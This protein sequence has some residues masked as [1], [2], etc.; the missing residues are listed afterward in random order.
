MGSRHRVIG[1]KYVFCDTSERLCGIVVV[2]AGST[3]CCYRCLQLFLVIFSGGSIGKPDIGTEGEPMF[4]ENQCNQ[5]TQCTVVGPLASF[6]NIAVGFEAAYTYCPCFG[7]MERYYFVA[8]ERTGKV[9]TPAPLG[10]FKN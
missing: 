3:F 6:H 7:W 5:F 4:I 1:I 10:I 8:S 9:K 2:N